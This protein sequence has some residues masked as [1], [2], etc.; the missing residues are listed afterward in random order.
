MQAAF[1]S[2]DI[3]FNVLIQSNSTPSISSRFVI[4]DHGDTYASL[5]TGIN[6]INPTWSYF[7]YIL[8]NRQRNFNLEYI[9]Q[10]GQGREMSEATA[11][12][13]KDI[14]LKQDGTGK[15]TCIKD[16]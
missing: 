10:M 11:N 2:K 3:N 15:C 5:A 16:L 7:V 6:A 14:I 1:G 4:N 12:T 13:I 8:P 9:S